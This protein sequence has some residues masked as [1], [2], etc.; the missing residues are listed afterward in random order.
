MLLWL[1]VSIV[2][3]RKSAL[4]LKSPGFHKETLCIWP[5]SITESQPIQ[6]KKDLP[7]CGRESFMAD[8]R[9]FS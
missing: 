6:K 5:A 3:L 7:S 2:T 8:R 1:S 4:L 9:F